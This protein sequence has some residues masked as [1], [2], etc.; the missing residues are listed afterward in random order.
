MFKIYQDLPESVQEMFTQALTVGGSKKEEWLSK[1]FGANSTLI[2]V[3][4]ALIS[5]KEML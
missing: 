5:V 3:Q 2:K 1:N 4:Q